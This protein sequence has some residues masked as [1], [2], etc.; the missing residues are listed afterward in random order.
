MSSGSVW[1]RTIEFD[2]ARVHAIPPD[3]SR[4]LP[5]PPVSTRLRLTSSDAA[6]R[7]QIPFESVGCRSGR[8]RPIPPDS[9]RFCPTPHDSIWFNLILDDSA[10]FLPIPPDFPRP[11]A[12]PESGPARPIPS[13]AHRLA[14]VGRFRTDFNK[15]NSFPLVLIRLCPVPP[16]SFR[17]RPTTFVSVRLRHPPPC[18]SAQHRSVRIRPVPP[19]FVRS[20]RIPCDP[21][22]FR[23]MPVDFS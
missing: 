6:R 9:V 4:F 20:C 10:R 22:R 8:F 11:R 2:P 15:N 17:F 5:I 23:L 19:D 21:V 16:D 7:R 13:D 3:S 18:E 1:S 14:D 12:P